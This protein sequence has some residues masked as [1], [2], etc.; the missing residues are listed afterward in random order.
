MG[1]VACQRS[2]GHLGVIW[3]GNVGRKCWGQSFKAD[4]CHCK[5]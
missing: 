2:F 3:D 4:V 5:I 1:V